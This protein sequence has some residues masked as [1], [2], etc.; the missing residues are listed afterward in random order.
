[1][2]ISDFSS[3][4]IICDTSIYFQNNSMASNLAT[5]FW[6]FGDGNTSFD[7][8]PTH[9]FS[10]PGTYNVLLIVTDNSACNIADTVLK[11]VY[12][13]SNSIHSFL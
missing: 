2:V 5:Y 8:N 9:T 7:K 3:P 6:D 12:V 13:L 11:E 1:M 4:G 10:Q